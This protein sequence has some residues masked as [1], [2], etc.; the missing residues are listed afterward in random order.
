MRYAVAVKQ[1]PDT[2]QVSVD[3]EGSLI[4]AGVP[5]ILDPYCE[6][7]LR[8][9]VALR[10][11]GDSIDVFTMGPPQAEEALRRCIAIGADRAFLLT[12]RDFAGADTWATARTLTAF[13]QRYEQDADLYVFGRQALD[14]ETGQVAAE[15]AELL[16]AQQFL[17]TRELEIG[18]EITAVQDYGAF[19]R[20]AEVPKGSI[21][22][23]GDVDPDGFLPT[24]D[25]I[26][27]ARKADIT[28]IGR[29]DVQLGLYSVGL[30]GSVTKIA[31]TRTSTGARRNVRIEITNPDTA[32]DF[33][34]KEGRALQ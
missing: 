28:R 12:D 17:Y 32:A 9:I 33:I 24:V 30:R 19:V 14:G 31:G 23:F 29:V 2:S 7:A 15:V 26:L 34:I 27:R 6:N 11:D 1:V 21:V 13:L 20:R 5:S 8:R 3:A 18:E 4:R 16:E 25:D 22:S 10:R